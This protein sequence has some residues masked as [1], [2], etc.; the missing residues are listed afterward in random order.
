MTSCLLG[1]NPYGLSAAI[2]GKS[3]EDLVFTMPS[4]SSCGYPTGG[5]LRALHV[6]PAAAP[7]SKWQ[8]AQ[9]VDVSL[10]RWMSNDLTLRPGRNHRVTLTVYQ[11]DI[12][13]AVVQNRVQ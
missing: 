8:R 2:T 5:A 1:A 13:I 12:D 9:T 10:L 6:D 3:A 4:G 11:N 7:A